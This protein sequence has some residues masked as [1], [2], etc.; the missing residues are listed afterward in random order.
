M[1]CPYTDQY[2]E[3][4]GQ[5]QLEECYA[6]VCTYSKILG[7]VGL[8]LSLIYSP[9]GAVSTRIRMRKRIEVRVS[10][11]QILQFYYWRTFLLIPLLYYSHLLG[12]QAN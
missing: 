7:L 1:V 5:T 11:Q 8:G 12:I 3:K 10:G 6:K 2:V 9:L 4:I